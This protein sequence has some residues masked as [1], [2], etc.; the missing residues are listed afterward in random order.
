MHSFNS[1]ALKGCIY[2]TCIFTSEK[3]KF[4]DEGAVTFKQ[5]QCFPLATIKRGV[6]TENTI[7]SF[8]RTG[9]NPEKYEVLTLYSLS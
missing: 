4:Y 2:V 6:A 7:C 8:L 5:I 3:W 9:P 1:V